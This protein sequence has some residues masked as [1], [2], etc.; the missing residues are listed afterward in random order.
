M[1][2]VLAMAAVA[3]VLPMASADAQWVFVARKAA[4]R[5]H[6]MTE[7]GVGGQPG[8]DFASVVLEAPADRVFAI[9]LERAQQNRAVHILMADPGARRLQVAEGDRTAT[10]NVVELSEG[11]SQLLIAGRSRPNEEA[12]SSQIVTAV[13][14]ICAEMKKT[15]ELAR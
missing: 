15:C 7:G 1:K 14:R 6:H 9:A 13:M 2:K 12:A 10:L 4:Q 5:I 8:Y 3:F 11:V